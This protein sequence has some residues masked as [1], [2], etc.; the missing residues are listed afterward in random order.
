MWELLI[1]GTQNIIQNDMHK[2]SVA[3]NCIIETVLCFL[4]DL[5]PVMHTAPHT[6]LYTDSGHIISSRVWNP[7]AKICFAVLRASTLSKKYS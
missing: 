3:Y 5:H 1:D 2:I 7:A 6:E 4:S